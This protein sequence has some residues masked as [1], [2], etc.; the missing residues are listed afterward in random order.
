[1]SRRKGRIMSLAHW[2]LRALRAEAQR[3]ALLNTI[4]TLKAAKAVVEPAKKVHKETV[5]RHTPKATESLD[6]AHD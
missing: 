5:V 2:K 4:A 3:D 6:I 1:M